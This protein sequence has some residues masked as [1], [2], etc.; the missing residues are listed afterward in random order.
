MGDRLQAG[1]PP[2]YFTKLPG[3]PSLLTQQDGK[4]VP[5]STVTLC[6][7]EVKA[8]WLIPR[9]DKREWH[10]KLCDP[11][12]TRSN[13]HIWAPYQWVRLKTQYKALHKC[14][15][16]YLLW[17]SKS[18]WLGRKM[19]KCTKPK[20]KPTVKELLTCVSIYHGVQ[21]SCRIQHRTVL[22]I[23]CLILQTDIIAQMPSVRGKGARTTYK[24][25]SDVHASST[26]CHEVKVANSSKK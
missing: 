22:T 12:L 24:Y 5:A 2:Q 23:F 1:K 13:F 10:V 21:L 4:W 6:G 25:E 15:L 7:W 8:G 20:P 14:C 19:Q 26:Q 18:V 17:H 9:E 16:F 3:Q 11:S